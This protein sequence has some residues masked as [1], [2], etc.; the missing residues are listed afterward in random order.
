M[1]VRM[2]VDPQLRN[3][4]ETY[5]DNAIPRTLFFCQNAK[6]NSQRKRVTRVMY[7]VSKHARMFKY[8]RVIFTFPLLV[9]SILLIER[10]R[11]LS[12]RDL[13]HRRFRVIPSLGKTPRRRSFD[14]RKAR[15]LLK[16][17]YLTT[18]KV[19]LSRFSDNRSRVDRS[20]IQINFSAYVRT[21]LAVL[22]Y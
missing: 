3:P 11:N 22:V 15:V 1:D 2:H 5:L 21:I 14:D 9:P 12:F 6:S 18:H 19:S 7:C 16:H 10:S 8:Q 4:V 13:F 17:R 20:A